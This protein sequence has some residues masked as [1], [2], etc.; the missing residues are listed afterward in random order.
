MFLVMLYEGQSCLKENVCSFSNVL[1][2]SCVQIRLRIKTF[3]VLPNAKFCY[4]FTLMLFS[5][6]SGG[7][8]MRQLPP[9]ASN[10]IDGQLLLLAPPCSWPVLT[11]IVGQIAL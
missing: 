10:V 6:T 2:S 11:P 4:L 8:I 3:L 5:V 9:M 7:L 1:G